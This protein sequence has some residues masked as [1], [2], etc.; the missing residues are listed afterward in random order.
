MPTSNEVKLIVN[1]R[2]QAAD[3]RVY[4]AEYHQVARGAGNL[5]VN[6]QRGVYLIR[7]RVG[8]SEFS[9]LTVLKKDAR[10]VEVPHLSFTSAA[11]LEQTA[12]THEYQKE[13]AAAHSTKVHVTA[14]E[15][16]WIYLFVRDW[17]SPQNRSAVPP[18]QNP[19][20]CLRLLDAQEQLIANLET[21]SFCGADEDPWAACNIAVNSGSYILELQFE[22]SQNLETA[23][24]D[25]AKVRAIRQTV[26]ASP[27]WQ[28]QVFCLLREYEGAGR[29]ADLNHAT[30]FMSRGLGFRPDDQNARLTELARLSLET[31]RVNV[32]NDEMKLILQGKFENPMLGIYGAHLTLLQ[33]ERRRRRGSEI[34]FSPDLTEWS[35]DGLEHVVSRLRDLVQVPHPDIEAVALAAELPLNLNEFSLP[36]MFRRSWSIIC[37]ATV[38]QTSLVPAGSPAERAGCGLWGDGQWLTW[39]DDNSK[40]TDALWNNIR[41]N[42]V[43]QRAAKRVLAAAEQSAPLIEGLA[44]EGISNF[45][46]NTAS[47]GP[48]E[49]EV[50]RLVTIFRVPRSKVEQLMQERGHNLSS[51]GLEQVSPLESLAVEDQSRGNLRQSE[52]ERS[53]RLKQMYQRVARQPVGRNL[54]NEANLSPTS[55]GL[56]NP[57][58]KEVVHF[59]SF[60]AP[61]TR[62]PSESNDSG[63]ILNAL[64]AIILPQQRPSVLIRGGSYAN[65]PSGPW[66]Y[67]NDPAT[68]ERLSH[69]LSSI[70]RIELPNV[71]SSAIRSGGTA[72]VVGPNLLLTS[73]SAVR[74]FAEVSG[75]RITYRSGDALIDFGREA[76]VVSPRESLV[77]VTGIR[78]IHPYWDVALLEVASLPPTARP[79]RLSVA[80]P[81]A[82][83][84]QDVAVIGHPSEDFHND[85]DVQNRI[86]DSIY[87]VKRLAPGKLSSRQ[88]VTLGNHQVEALTYDTS[89]VGS[90]TGAVVM[91]IA[92]GDV[93]GLHFSGEYLKWNLGVPMSEL[94]R[95][96]R[97]ADAGLN[98]TSNVGAATDWLPAWDRTEG[99]SERAVSSPTPIPPMM[100]V[101]GAPLAPTAGQ[102]VATLSLPL[103]ISVSIGP[104]VITLP[105][106]V[107]VAP[108][109]VVTEG[110]FGSDLPGVP[111]AQI[112]SRFSGSSLTASTFQWPTAL[113][114]VL[115]SNLVYQVPEF[116]ANIGL[117]V[118]RLTTCNSIQVDDT[119]C[120]V[121]STPQAVLVSFR[122]TESSGDWLANL[123]ALSITR[124]YG[125]VHRGFYG[126][127]LSVQADLEQELGRFPGRPILI[128]G[129]SL[130]GAIAT[131]AAAEWR[132]RFPVAGVYTFGQPAVGTARFSEFMT[133]NFGGKLFRFVNNN[134]IVPR[135]PPGYVHVGR[136]FH[137]DSQGHLPTSIESA[138]DGLGLTT[139]EPPMLTE[140]Q[141]D[142]LRANLLAN[143]AKSQMGSGMESLEGANLEGLIPSAWDHALSQYNGRVLA[144]NS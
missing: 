41:S 22:G 118:W 53:R 37:D 79:L 21:A 16:S 36:P 47:V 127:F 45:E 120:F 66:E 14:G 51:T 15:G 89:T 90:D 17:T 104:P 106:P 33:R 81:N 132:D 139:S 71:P 52:Q 72:F 42:V 134:D 2:D 9:E 91:H 129:H 96:Q 80:P 5:D 26:V 57:P 65:L 23:N 109:A 77:P 103:Q 136:L 124:P 143:R 82:L 32:G 29:S 54:F 97:V 63:E 111:F 20:R 135:V 68:R 56:F 39:I 114:M 125:A 138:F 11:P 69:A 60:S 101:P 76:D 46:S 24:G 8:D 94:A 92:T 112:V 55:D 110:W 142:E 95:D 75:E 61:Q 43:Y 3:I 86:F 40:I 140:A 108:S 50:E 70:G 98:F 1:T 83:I 38:S 128:T 117:G 141:F 28:T 6:L 44:L 27:G 4:D 34:K 85:M 73:G 113:S 126:Q 78:M 105:V 116:V 133:A 137:F 130:G 13:A 74:L 122:G 48:T 100:V 58:G 87:G 67:L 99:T 30:I 10:T 93:I 31:G 88:R 102:S 107:P 121:A 119:Q 84:G 7:A 62:G 25:W 12:K 64:E 144:M 123:N 19:M 131:I 59:E 115:A 49:E 18:V 35:E